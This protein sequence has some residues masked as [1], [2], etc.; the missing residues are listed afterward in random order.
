VPC[1][2][3][4]REVPRGNPE[5][6]A[7]RLSREAVPVEVVTRPSR[8]EG[9]SPGIETCSGVTGD[10]VAEA[11]VLITVFLFLNDIAPGYPLA[12]GL[13]KL[14]VLSKERSFKKLHLLILEVE[15]SS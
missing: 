12:R 8:G 4:R 11:E 7:R 2:S 6:P 10:V 1:S 13:R 3:R 5:W 14:G 15:P 9:L